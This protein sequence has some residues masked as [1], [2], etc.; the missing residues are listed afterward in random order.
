MTI[1]RSLGFFPPKYQHV[2]GCNGIIPFLIVSKT[3]SSVLLDCRCSQHHHAAVAFFF[4]PFL[5]HKLCLQKH[6]RV[7][8]K[9]PLGDGKST[10][11][12]AVTSFSPHS[13]CGPPTRHC[14]SHIACLSL[15][16]TMIE[17]SGPGFWAQLSWYLW[18]LWLLAT[19]NFHLA[20][21]F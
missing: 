7:S 16:T 12:I 17:F 19:V 5:K 6:R 9:I 20:K 14:P 15:T 3:Q 18:A 8:R 4:F 13:M 11:N 1:G 21:C 2:S 10:G